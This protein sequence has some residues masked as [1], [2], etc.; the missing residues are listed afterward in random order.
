MFA[1]LAAPERVGEPIE[2]GRREARVALAQ[3]NG[4]ACDSRGTHKRMLG[5]DISRGCFELLDSR[6]WALC[7]MLE[8]FL[9]SAVAKTSTVRRSSWNEAADDRATYRS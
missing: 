8:C 6:A 9:T 3:S 5:P 1:R 4:V 7:S 2:V